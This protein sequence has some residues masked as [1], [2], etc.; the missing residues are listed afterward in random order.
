MERYQKKIGTL[1]GASGGSPNELTFASAAALS[2]V[3]EMHAGPGTVEE[4]KSS[5]LVTAERVSSKMFNSAPAS[6]HKTRPT[7]Q[8]LYSLLVLGLDENRR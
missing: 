6:F 4:T 5:Y 3:D 7:L 8:G 1:S 2:V